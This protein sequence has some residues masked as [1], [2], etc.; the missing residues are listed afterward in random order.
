LGRRRH[1]ELPHSANPG[2]AH[3]YR[4]ETLNTYHKL[5]PGSSLPSLPW[6]A[7]RAARP[8]RKIRYRAPCYLRPVKKPTH[9]RK[10]YACNARFWFETH[11]ANNKWLGIK[12][13]TSAK[14]LKKPVLVWL[15]PVGTRPGVPGDD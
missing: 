9:I 6:R 14:K 4:Q 5:K 1:E 2:C 11:R 8:S 12:V 7:F 3:L 13:K 15:L 10:T